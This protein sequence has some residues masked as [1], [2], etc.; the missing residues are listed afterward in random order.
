MTAS[1]GCEHAVTLGLVFSVPT[2]CERRCDLK[3]SVQKY[4]PHRRTIMRARVRE[5]VKQFWHSIASRGK[6]ISHKIVRVV[7]SLTGARTPPILGEFGRH[8]LIGAPILGARFIVSV[9]RTLKFVGAALALIAVTMF[10]GDWLFSS[11]RDVPYRALSERAPPCQEGADR[12]WDVLAS[13]D[14]KQVANDEL[15]AIEK[16]GPQWQMKLACVIQH[17]VIPYVASD[18]TTR[19]LEYRLA[20]LEFHED[21]K[22]YALREPCSEDCA[23]DR[24][25]RVD[26]GKRS[27]LGAILNSIDSMG[28][29]Y[30]MVFVHGWRHDASIGD[31]NLADFRLYAAHVA[32]FLEDRAILDP[33]TPKPQLTAIY[34]GWR[35]ART[36]ETWLRRKFGVFGKWIGGFLAVGTLFDRKPVSEAIAPSVLN[37]L[38]AIDSRLNIGRPIPDVGYVPTNKN[39]MIVFG[40][41]LGGNLLITALREDLVKL[42]LKHVGGTYVQPVLGDLVVLINPAAEASKWIEMQRALWQRL[43]LESAERRPL[44]EYVVAHR[45]FRRDQVPIIVSATATRDWPPGGYAETDCYKQIWRDARIEGFEYDW[46]TFDLFPFFKG[47]FRPLADTLERIALQRDPRNACDNT[48]TPWYRRIYMSP[49]YVVSQFL[50]VFPFMNT[51]PEESRTL[52]HL[53]PPLGG[54][55]ITGNGLGGRPFGTTHELMGIEPAL[56][57]TKRKRPGKRELPLSYLDVTSPEAGCPVAKAW[58]LKARVHATLPDNPYGIAWNSEGAGPDA[59]ALKFRHGFE[60]PSRPPITRPN[61]PFWNVRAFDTALARHD[62]YLL[63]S[64]ICAMNQFVMDDPGGHMEIAKVTAPSR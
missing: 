17:H 13:T 50:R 53:D 27:Q 23:D 18:G 43:A 58:L 52:G 60:Y 19:K 56:D 10:F 9:W 51:N 28:P 33:N 8:I 61:D 44:G 34:V 5:F 22:P 37:A 29:H 47:D 11:P 12:G 59:P 6:A 4:L 20:F 55:D 62:G 42:V 1:V 46:A 39:K 30:V 38:R 35:G 41:S 49:V 21:G 57:R 54:G 24:Y 64:F 63:S 2:R 32:R 31:S 7:T 15:S 14:N 45:F 36:D 16:K 25:G 48:L 3:A 26:I 40:H